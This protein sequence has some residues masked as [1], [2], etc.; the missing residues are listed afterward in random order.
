MVGDAES[1]AGLADQLRD[2]GLD[3]DHSGE[4]P[5][6]WYDVR[7]YKSDEALVQIK[8]LRLRCRRG[9]SG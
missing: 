3:R 7:Y 5:R 8:N 4:G 1:D 9:E 6:I 2:H